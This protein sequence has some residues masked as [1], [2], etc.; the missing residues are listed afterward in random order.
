MAWQKALLM[1]EHLPGWR[2]SRSAVTAH[3]ASVSMLQPVCCRQCHQSPGGKQRKAGHMP[4]NCTAACH[5]S[6]GRCI[7]AICRPGANAS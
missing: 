3:Q 6:N 2:P 1:Y 7:T 4:A 5:H